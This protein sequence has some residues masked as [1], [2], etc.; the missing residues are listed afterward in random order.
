MGGLLGGDARPG[1]QLPPATGRPPGAAATR[2]PSASEQSR[3]GGLLVSFSDALAGQRLA[4]PGMLVVHLLHRSFRCR[5][6]PSTRLARTPTWS[7]I[8][9][10]N[11]EPGL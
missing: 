10:P 2:R 7:P 11:A 9:G 8:W 1:G 5:R 3:M 6:G 4:Q